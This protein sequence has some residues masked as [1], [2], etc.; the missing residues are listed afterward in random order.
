M[1]EEFCL[2]LFKV[3]T[4]NFQNNGCET[5]YCKCI[6]SC[7]IVTNSITTEKLVD[8]CLFTD[9]ILPQGCVLEKIL[10]LQKFNQ[11]GLDY[12]NKIFENLRNEE[13]D[14]KYVDD[15][16]QEIVS[17]NNKCPKCLVLKYSRRLSD[18]KDAKALS[19]LPFLLAAVARDCSLMVTF[20]KISSEVKT[21]KDFII[22]S[23]YG[24]FAVNVGILDLYPKPVSTIRK[25][26]DRNG[27]I[28][29]AYIS[30]S[31]R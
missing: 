8:N 29:N 19:L 30:L 27:K 16:V 4:T 31:S 25:S 21:S 28:S 3:L 5:N 1:L 23:T 15:C 18:F 2:L 24:S 26:L 14:W 13:D 9:S 6:S 7:P 22:D 17:N 20:N 11:Y 10:T 12:Y